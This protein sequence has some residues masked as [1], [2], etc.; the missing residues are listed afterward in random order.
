[1]RIVLAGERALGEKV[2]KS[3]L[4]QGEQVVGVCTPP[5]APN[6][7]NRVRETAEEARVPVLPLQ[8]VKTPQF[9][10]AYRAM[11][12]NLTVMAYVTKI[13]PV[14][15]FT[16]PTIGAIEWHPSL[17]PA[18]GGPNALNWPIIQGEKMTGATIFWP[19][20][21]ID[22]GPI[23]LQKEVEISPDDTVASLYGKLFPVSIEA[24]LEAVA[25]VKQGAAPRI[26]QDTT[27]ATYEGFCTADD[28]WINWRLPARRL[29]D[30]IR[31]TNPAPAARTTARGQTVL[32]LDSA[33]LP[34]GSVTSPGTI[35]SITDAGVQLAADGGAILV[36]RAGIPGSAPVEAPSLFR[37]LE[38]HEGDVLGQ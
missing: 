34:Q 33:L 13:L 8:N 32:L 24:L 7:P 22:T 36:K 12:P 11:A 23:L 5:D 18:H 38:L 35:A 10:D 3:L 25:L 30:L 26:P 31:G 4:K 2:L 16:I 37:Q 15:F 17:L 14:D 20:G 27:R 19:D 29:Y 6:A 28:A 21:G 1:M 9:I